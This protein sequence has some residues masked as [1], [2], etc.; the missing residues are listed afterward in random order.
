MIWNLLVNIA[1]GE[2][3]SFDDDTRVLVNGEAYDDMDLMDSALTGA[4]GSFRAAGQYST[5]IRHLARCCLR[6]HQDN[7][8]TLER[9]LERVKHFIENPPV[10][11]D[12]GNKTQWL[13]PS[14][15]GFDKFDRGVVNTGEDEDESD[16]DNGEDSSNKEGNAEDSGDS[17]R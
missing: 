16:E 5:A 13:L 7:R 17:A 2:D 10:D 3:P 11:I 15:H 4:E 14:E 9:L 12:Q 8:P 1:A 6:W